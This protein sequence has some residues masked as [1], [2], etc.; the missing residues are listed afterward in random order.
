MIKWKRWYQVEHIPIRVCL[1]GWL[2]AGADQG[3]FHSD[4]NLVFYSDQNKNKIPSQPSG[5]KKSSIPILVRIG[6]RIKFSLMIEKKETYSNL[7]KIQSPYCSKDSNFYFNLNLNLES[8]ALEIMAIL[9][10]FDFGFN[11]DQKLN[12]SFFNIPQLRA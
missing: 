10:H 7:S 1:V 5:W 9:I 2:W 4:S 12:T 8:N 6:I 3:V 11:S